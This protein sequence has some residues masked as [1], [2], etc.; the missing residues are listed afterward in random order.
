M[1][2]SLAASLI[3]LEENL[4]APDPSLEALR[5]I[6]EPERLARLFEVQ[7]ASGVRRGP[8]VS[9]GLDPAGLLTT[10][11]RL[12]ARGGLPLPALGSLRE[13]LAE[14]EQAVRAAGAWDDS[15]L[16]WEPL[17]EPCALERAWETL[18]ASVRIPDAEIRA[19]AFA[20]DGAGRLVVPELLG[21]GWVETVHRGL[22]TAWQEGRLALEQGGVGRDGRPS[23]RRSD[24]VTYLAGTEARWLEA[25]PELA[26]LVQWGLARWVGRLGPEISPGRELV[27][28][29][30]AMLARYPAPSGGYARHMDNPG[31]EN[32]N[33]RTRT[34]V[35]YL[36]PPT[37]A[38]R[39][40]Q[41]ALWSPDAGGE[42]GAAEICEPA[43]G[44]LAIFDSRRVPHRVM[45]LEPGPGRW[46][47]TFWL[48]S[49]GPPEP[50]LPRP[51]LSADD[52]LRPLMSPTVSGR[53]S[54]PRGKVLLH[55]VGTPADRIL[56]ST[57]PDSRP[58]AAVVSTV[59]RPPEPERWCRH[60]LEQGF[61]HLLLIFD[62]GE[63][64]EERAVID[65]LRSS[66]PAERLTIW[67]G[68]EVAE[69]RWPDVLAD[70]RLAALEPRARE[71]AS[72]HA[73]ACRQCL[74][75]SAALAAFRAGEPGGGWDWLLHLD[76]DELFHLQGSGQGGRDVAEHFAAVAAAGYERVRYLNH[77]RLPGE[78]R[79][80]KLNPRLAEIQLGP[81]GWEA[82]VAHLD[83]AQTAARPYFLSYFNG[84]SAVSV[85]DGTAAAGVHGWWSND[86]SPEAEL[87][88]AGPSILHEPRPTAES[89]RGKYFTI[90]AAPRPSGERQFAPSLVEERALALIESTSAGP[91]L[92]ERLD[93]LYRRLHAFSEQ[94]LAW[95]GEAGLLYRPREGVRLV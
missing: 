79:C 83:L 52:V 18:E 89:F 43:G 93:A 60:H 48:S 51:K 28:P 26:L 17:P 31:G 34:L 68:S 91:E 22:E 13:R 27:A 41:L 25:V 85:P 38:C 82:L 57:V 78:D 21:S 49:G 47:L 71:G 53:A 8:S 80:F 2:S 10:A 11:Q 69:T 72:S 33:G 62:R 94:D 50:P 77:E 14:W 61:E 39:G 16:W 42:E 6:A 7:M 54:V 65:T 24:F 66:F 75:A 88:V 30:R 4:S 95:L 76:A 73:V 32:D 37:M 87:V 15:P 1:R 12:V 29:Q 35:L 20:A 67:L 70:P 84:K 36:N 63:D 58:R 5:D 90:A 9:K 81:V 44:T 40:G 74:N 23:S 55:D 19:R 64:P 56:V 86:P 92:Q 46:A 3:E 59:F 45:P